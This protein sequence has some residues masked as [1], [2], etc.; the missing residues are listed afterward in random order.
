MADW[1]PIPHETPLPDRS[2]LIQKHIKSRQDLHRAEARNVGRA[3]LKYLSARPSRRI[4]PFDLKWV[5]RLHKE[6]FGEV[7]M[8]AGIRRDTDLNIGVPWHRVETDL[9]Q[10][11]DDLAYWRTHK[12]LPS[13]DQAV[14]VHFKAVA[15]HPFL[16]GN[17]RW[18][19]ML[20]NIL[21]RQDAEPI[22][23]WPSD[24][25]GS[26]SPIRTEYIAAIQAADRGDMQPLTDLHARYREPFLV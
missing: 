16:N 22:V 23:A 12:V 26:T 24:E 14:Q 20:A 8:W 9:Q 6:M 3:V 21:L 1:E 7:W 17:G 18:A 4:A 15:I 5:Y 11:L 19:R 10:M 13:F 25:I 2:G